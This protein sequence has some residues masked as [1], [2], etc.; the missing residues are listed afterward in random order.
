[1]AVQRIYDLA[2]GSSTRHRVLVDR[3]WPRGITKADAPVDEWVKEVAPSTDLRRWYDHRVD[4]FDEF[5]R[6][7]RVE[8]TQ[9]FARDAVDR[10]RTVARS[11][12]LIL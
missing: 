4:R 9:Q 8:L 3:L 12:G 1:M 11:N 10:L 6:R 5:V 7:Y 2:P